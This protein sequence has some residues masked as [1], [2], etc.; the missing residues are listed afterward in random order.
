MAASSIQ[1]TS[2]PALGET[3][4][5]IKTGFER[6]VGSYKNGLNRR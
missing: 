2:F 4:I 3:S 1:Y 5:R 6:I